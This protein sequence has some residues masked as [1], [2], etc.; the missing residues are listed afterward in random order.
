MY[1]GP[2]DEWTRMTQLDPSPV[3]RIRRLASSRGGRRVP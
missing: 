2:T 1:L 3:R